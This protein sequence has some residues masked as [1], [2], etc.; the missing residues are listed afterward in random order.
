MRMCLLDPL[1]LFLAM[2]FAMQPPPVPAGDTPKLDWGMDAKLYTYA[3]VSRACAADAKVLAQTLPAEEMATVRYLS[4]TTVPKSQREAYA[5]VANMLLNSLSRKRAIMP[6]FLGG[7]DN[8]FVRFNLADYGI[9]SEQYYTLGETDS[10]FHERLVPLTIEPKTAKQVVKDKAE[11]AAAASWLDS[12]AI[13]YLTKTLQTSV[14]LLRADW[15]VATASLPPHYYNLLGLKTLDD[16]KALALYDERAE[17]L[18]LAAATIVFSGEKA[19]AVARNNRVL[20]RVN[21]ATGAWWKT[22]D[23]KTSVKASNVIHNF[24]NNKF[25]GSEIIFTLPNGLQGYFL[26][27]DKDERVDE[28][29]IDIAVDSTAEDRRVRNGRSCIICHSQGIQPFVSAFKTQVDAKNLIDLGINVDGDAKKAI[30]LAR[31]IK[32]V[33]EYP[34]F[35][36]IIKIDNERYNTA[37]KAASGKT[38]VAN[39]ALFRQVYD[40]YA[41]KPLNIKRLVWEAGVPEDQVR[42]AIAVKIGGVNN[43]VLLRYLSDSPGRRDHLEESFGVLMQGV[44]A[45]QKK[46]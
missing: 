3:D 11:I 20:L 14:P 5:G 15:F 27:N 32:E 43:G 7:P 42:A 23:Y 40:D 39:A 35:A 29:P 31:K 46:E 9:S 22:Q 16:V 26:T 33:F 2:T 19:T 24:L 21:T 37:V 12:E 38:A 13:A 17:K 10:Y 6:L 41:E 45:T 30:A 4:L 1:S 8:T 44:L 36:A 25:D 18:T 34:D 28:V